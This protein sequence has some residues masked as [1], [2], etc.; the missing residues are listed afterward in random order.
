MGHKRSQSILASRFCLSWW[1][2]T[3]RLASTETTGG[4]YMELRLVVG[5][6]FSSRSCFFVITYTPRATIRMHRS[7]VPPLSLIYRYG[8]GISYHVKPEKYMRQYHQ[9]WTP[10]LVG[11]HNTLCP[12]HTTFTRSTPIYTYF[13]IQSKDCARK[14]LENDGEFWLTCRVTS[15]II[16]IINV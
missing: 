4:S 12:P 1:V 10:N 13:I 16:N 14:I 2:I 8:L 6:G 5:D 7:I 15:V 9:K 11:K 3:T